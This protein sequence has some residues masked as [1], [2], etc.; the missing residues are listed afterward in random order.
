ML[1]YAEVLFVHAESFGILVINPV[2][3]YCFEKS[4]VLQLGFF[5]R[6][7]VRYPRAIVVN[8]WDQ[9][10]KALDRVRF[11]LVVKL[12]VGGS[13]AGIVRFISWEDLVQRFDTFDFGPDGTVLVQEY[14]ELAEDAIVRVEV[15][16]G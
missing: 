7:G 13:G 12:N 1:F 15:L 9:V 6:L 5:E 14:I 2:V 10:L 8:Y 4:K 16:D 3:A 11:L